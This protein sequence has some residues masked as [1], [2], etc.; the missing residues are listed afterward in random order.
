MTAARAVLVA[1][2]SLAIA[3]GGHAAAG[4]ALPPAPGLLALGGVTLAVGAVL[5]RRPLAAVTLVPV[6]GALQ[7]GL[8]HGFELLHATAGGAPAAVEGPHGAHAAHAALQVDPVLGAVHGATGSSAWMLVAHVV[9]VAVTAALLVGADAGARGV[10]RWWAWVA[11]LLLS[12]V[13]LPVVGLPARLVAATRV[14]RSVPVRWAAVAPRR[15]P[16][17]G[18]PAGC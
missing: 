3:A 12:R 4:G 14:V 17:V 10:A 9:A 5:G 15:G 7:V 6:L 8:H 2:L 13:L 1:L 18:S 11:P 16:P